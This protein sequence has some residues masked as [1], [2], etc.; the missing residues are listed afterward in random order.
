MSPE[1]HYPLL[2]P[3]S[4]G[5][6]WSL[7]AC[8]REQFSKVGGENP[9]IQRRQV[10]PA[11][12]QFLADKLIFALCACVCVAMCAN[13]PGNHKRILLS[14]SPPSV[15]PWCRACCEDTLMWGLLAKARLSVTVNSDSFT[16]RSVGLAV[17]SWLIKFEFLLRST[18]LIL[19]EKYPVVWVWFLYIP[20]WS[21][22][23]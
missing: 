5:P 7:P 10:F 6:T 16:T 19:M 2:K 17:A 22:V 11:S 18:L 9:L 23:R 15:W 13:S 20:I 4:S 8:A 14:R 12:I 1:S 21:Y 3:R